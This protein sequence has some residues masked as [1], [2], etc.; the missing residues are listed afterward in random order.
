MAR[1]STT[2]ESFL[3][4]PLVVIGFVILIVSLAGF[5]GACFHVAW[6]L[7]LYLVVMLFIIA[8]L[9]GLTIFGFIVTGQGDGSQVPGRVYREYH[10]EDYSPWLRRRVEDYHYWRTIKGC[11]WGSKT[12]AKL[13]SWTPLDYMARDMTPIQVFCKN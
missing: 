9:M 12:C 5:I 10:L 4:T 6:A 8:T 2:C 7:W 3:Q 1:N 11:I 13:A